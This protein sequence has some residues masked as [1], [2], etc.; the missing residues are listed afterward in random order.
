MKRKCVVMA[1]VM[2]LMMAAQGCGNGQGAEDK[3][4]PIPMETMAGQGEGQQGKNEEE[5]SEESLSPTQDNVGEHMSHSLEDTGMG[6][7]APEEGTDGGNVA[8]DSPLKNGAEKAGETMIIGGK[9]REIMEESFVISRVQYADDDRTMVLIPEEGSPEEELVTV[10]CTDSTA[11]EHW[12]IQGGGAGIDMKEAAFADIQK[13]GGL[14][15]EGYFDG[16]KF[17][18]E[19]VIIETYE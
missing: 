10:Q 3:N 2:L 8:Q 13:G 11:F 17:V 7:S 18:A 9:V 6:D 14:E 12:T 5:G 19:K 16:D 15:A 4:E 1:G